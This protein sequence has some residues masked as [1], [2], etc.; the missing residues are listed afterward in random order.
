MTVKWKLR[1]FNNYFVTDQGWIIRNEYTTQHQHFKDSRFI[2]K[3]SRNQFTLYRDGV[4]EIWSTKQLR[5]IL[6]G[7]DPIF[8]DN[9]CEITNTPFQVSINNIDIDGTDIIYF[10]D[11]R[12]NLCFGAITSRKARSFDTSGLGLTCVPC[13]SV[14]HLIK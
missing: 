8:I 10:K 6:I 11:K 2:N 9:F 13:D 14:K 7:I 12:T 3:N 1:G 4:K 5:N